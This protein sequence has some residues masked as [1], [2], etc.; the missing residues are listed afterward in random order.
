MFTIAL[1]F[2][3]FIIGMIIGVIIDECDE[4]GYESEYHYNYQCGGFRPIRGKGKPLPPPG[5]SE[6]DFYE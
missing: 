5:I 2:M 3:S 6:E 1:C 4:K